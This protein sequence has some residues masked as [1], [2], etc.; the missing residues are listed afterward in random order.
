MCDGSVCSG[1]EDNAA[2]TGGGLAAGAP[3]RA[4][5]GPDSPRPALMGGL[6]EILPPSPLLPP[7]SPLLLPPSPLPPPPAP[8]LPPLSPLLPP[9]AAAAVARGPES[10]A[11]AGLAVFFFPVAAELGNGARSSDLSL[12]RLPDFFTTVQPPSSPSSDASTRGNETAVFSERPPPRLFP[13]G[14]LW[15]PSFL[16]GA[17]LTAAWEGGLG[18]S[19]RRPSA[20]GP[21]AAPPPTSAEHFAA[22]ASPGAC[23]ATG[24]AAA[25]AGPHGKRVSPSGRISTT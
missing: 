9:P 25:D 5:A 22:G 23:T 24:P 21:Q 16:D 13:F 12:P 19:S 2:A 15:R 3:C 17:A 20:P 10:F 1:A 4:G 14:A 8:L 18:S 6:A 7:P 11:E